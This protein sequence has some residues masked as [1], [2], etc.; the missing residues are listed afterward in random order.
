MDLPEQ[1]LLGAGISL[2][3]YVAAQLSQ[4]KGEKEVWRWCAFV[5]A[6][7]VILQL[8]CELKL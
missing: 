1:V 5:W 4:T 3:A 2:A 8:S 6:L 7:S